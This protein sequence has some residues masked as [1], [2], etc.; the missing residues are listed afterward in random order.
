MEL[1]K[2]NAILRAF[3]T[4][5]AKEITLQ[6][7]LVKIHIVRSKA[8]PKQSP[9]DSSSLPLTHLGGEANSGLSN[10]KQIHNDIVSNQV[11]YFSRF[12]PKEKKQI[13]KLR[14]IVKKGDLVA[15]IKSAHI[16]HKV[17][18]ETSGKIIEFLVE[19]GQPVEYGQP[20]IRLD[21]KEPA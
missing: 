6:S 11:G 7:K 18:S 13:V 16:E 14:D 1:K 17:F 9:R 15:I 3:E 2:L 5:S 21:N 8:M 12:N 10:G 19:E 20:L 4:T